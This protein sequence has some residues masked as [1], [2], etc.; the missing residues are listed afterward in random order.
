MTIRAGGLQQE[1][2]YRVEA[3]PEAGDQQRVLVIAAED[4]TGDLTEPRGP[5][6]TSRRATSRST[7]RRSRPRATRSRRSTSTPRPRGPAASRPGAT[8]RSSGVLSHFDAIV[9]Y[10]G[11]D[12][13]PQETTETNA[14]HLPSATQQSGSTILASWA[15]KTMLAM[16]DYLNEGGKAIV[17]GRN[18]HQWPTQTRSLTD[19]PQYDW[20]PDSC[21]GSSTR[22]A[23]QATTTCPGRR[24]SATA[25]SRTTRGRTTSAPSGA[26]AATARRRSRRAPPSTID[27]RASSRAWT[28]PRCR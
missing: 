1:F 19:T 6:T 3:V 8:R 11:D 23:T 17:A 20:A 27:R 14:R 12:F 24:S 4:Y 5:A 22:R 16:R 15:H 10:S 9:W 26:R 25:T 2:S 21:P 7:C 28:R 13:I 18:I